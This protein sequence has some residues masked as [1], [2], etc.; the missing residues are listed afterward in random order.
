MVVHRSVALVVMVVVVA[1]G[2]TSPSGPPSSTPVPS[3]TPVPSTTPVP[4]ASPTPAP[5]DVSAPFL[6]AITDPGFE[7]DME[8]SGTVTIAGT[9][10]TITGFGTVSGAGSATSITLS[11]A[12]RDQINESIEIGDEGWARRAPGPWLVDPPSKS[13]M[14]AF[15]EAMT[16]AVDLGVVDLDGT[17]FHHLQPAGGNE[18]TPEAA[19]FDVEGARDAAFTIDFYAT[20]DGTPAIIALGGAW[21]Q[22][23][24]GQDV[25]VEV[26]AAYTLTPFTG[27][28]EPPTDVWEFH[29]SKAF[30][31]RMAHPAEWTV[32]ASKSQDTYGVGGQG[33]VYVAPQA[34]AKG[35]KLAGFVAALRKSYKRDFGVDPIID[36]PTSL[37]GAAAHRL[38]YRFTNADDVEVTIAD[39]VTVHA[40]KG[41]EVFLASSGGDEDV[42]FFEI[43][44]ATFEFTDR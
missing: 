23:A 42:A 31:Y 38:V 37:A 25:T 14:R 17:S 26:G 24:D 12:G 35:T 15:L 19:G 28:L 33:Y 34:V 5:V 13:S 7:A 36:E 29:A 18:L 30:D 32:K 21:T 8:I 20:D 22:T 27:L 3:A 11:I 1:C 44:T 40:G 39:V 16:G 6:A 41:W 4:T 43:F 9:E 2:G 10:G